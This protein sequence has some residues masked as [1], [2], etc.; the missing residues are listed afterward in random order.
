MKL[1]LW[2]VT[3][4][5]SNK[6]LAKNLQQHQQHELTIFNLATIHSKG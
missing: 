2:K 4:D 3:L 5:W 6:S 1:G